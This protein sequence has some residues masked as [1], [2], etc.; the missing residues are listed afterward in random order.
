MTFEQD[1]ERERT[2]TVDPDGGRRLWATPPERTKAMDVKINPPSVL[3]LSVGDLTGYFTR[4]IK[5]HSSLISQNS[6]CLS[7]A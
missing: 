1:L 7:L 5:G 6:L 3:L 2:G 4:K